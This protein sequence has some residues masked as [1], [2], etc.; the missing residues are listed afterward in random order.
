M[1]AHQLK[2]VERIIDELLSVEHDVDGVR[3]GRDSVWS[4]SQR[5]RIEAAK[6]HIHL[7][8]AALQMNFAELASNPA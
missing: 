7:A 3:A 5:A 2:E 8:R 1:V 6:T 4:R